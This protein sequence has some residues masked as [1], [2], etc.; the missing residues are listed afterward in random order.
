MPKVGKS[1]SLKF[2]AK[3][4]LKP[5]PME[6]MDGKPVDGYPLYAS[7][8]YGASS[9]SIKVQD[10]NGQDIYVT[11]DLAQLEEPHFKP[12]ADQ[13]SI[14]MRDL[15]AKEAKL[16]GKQYKLA[17]IGARRM[18]YGHSLYLEIMNISIQD[19]WG[20]INPESGFV[21]TVKP[22]DKKILAENFQAVYE[23]IQDLADGR[24]IF[25]LTTIYE[26]FYGDAQS[27]M[28]KKFNEKLLSKNNYNEENNK[29]IVNSLIKIIDAILLKKVFLYLV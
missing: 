6:T 25:F 23:C 12:Y 15:V 29:K 24:M 18:K 16:I 1:I 20:A 5:I 26:W 14:V 19:F 3:Q 11:K 13:Y 22:E 2:Y 7:L 28:K 9:T 8:V 27:K 17:G 4:D 21:S 10:Q